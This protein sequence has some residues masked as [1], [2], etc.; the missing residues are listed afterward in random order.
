[1]ITKSGI[2]PNAILKLFLQYSAQAEFYSSTKTILLI[3]RIYFYV[4]ELFYDRGN[5][6]EFTSLVKELAKPGEL[7]GARSS[8]DFEF[9]NVE[10]PYETYTGANVRLRFVKMY[11]LKEPII[12][13]LRPSPTI[14]PCLFN[15]WTLHYKRHLTCLAM[16]KS[17]TTQGNSFRNL[18]S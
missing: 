16:F 1:M 4:L 18:L 7:L 3:D 12:W 6:H 5:H 11:A 10:K 13:Y 15:V 17:T 2:T 8:Y 14:K 9:V